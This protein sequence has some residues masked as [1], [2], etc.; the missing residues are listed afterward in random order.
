M[1]LGQPAQDV[2][3]PPAAGT[4]PTRPDEFCWPTLGYM[5]QVI[6]GYSESV[7]FTSGTERTPVASICQ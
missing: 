4:T 3:G 7:L 5:T 6:S 1:A 2:A